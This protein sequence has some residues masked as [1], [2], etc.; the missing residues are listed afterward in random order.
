M[1]DS[2]V[3]EIMLTESKLCGGRADIDVLYARSLLKRVFNPLYIISPPIPLI[4]QTA[5][6]QPSLR[7]QC[8]HQISIPTSY[9][10]VYQ[11]NSL[12]FPHNQPSS[13]TDTA[14]RALEIDIGT[15]G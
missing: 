10:V 12:T 13:P 2:L 4:L 11:G 14:P 1:I 5:P 6:I 3:L 9:L 15:A 8:H 7:F